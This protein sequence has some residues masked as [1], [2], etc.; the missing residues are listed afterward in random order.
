MLSGSTISSKDI[1]LSRISEELMAEIV[2]KLPSPVV[3]NQTTDLHAGFLL[4]VQYVLN[5]L[6]EH[7]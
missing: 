5:V 7:Q 1:R 2:K 4:G 6:K 3:N